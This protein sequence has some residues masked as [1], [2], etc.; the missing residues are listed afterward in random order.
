MGFAQRAYLS[1]SR[2]RLGKEVFDP[3]VQVAGMSRESYPLC[4]GHFS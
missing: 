3:C 2:R 4:R 1:L